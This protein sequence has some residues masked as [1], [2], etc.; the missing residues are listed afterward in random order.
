M[1]DQSWVVIGMVIYALNHLW[2]IFDLYAEA[3]TYF[4]LRTFSYH[5][6]TLIKTAFSLF[7]AYLILNVEF[8]VDENTTIDFANQIGLVIFLSI[9]ATFGVMESFALKIGHF[10]IIDIGQVTA[11]F[12]TRVLEEA[13]NKQKLHKR[14]ETQSVA[15]KLSKKCPLDQLEAEF[16]LVMEVPLDTSKEDLKNMEK[17]AE[18]TKVPKER[19]LAQR[20]ANVDINRAQKLLKATTTNG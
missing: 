5:V 14:K 18:D 6:F 8:K 15:E 17:F 7:A 13:K 20:I 2:N 11:S 4:F 10:R 9:F 16:F 12:R 1:D 3:G 19:L